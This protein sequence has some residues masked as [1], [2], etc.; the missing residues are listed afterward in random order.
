M[1]NLLLFFPLPIIGSSEENESFSRFLP[2]SC[3]GSHIPCD[4]YEPS[5][6][7]LYQ[8]FVNVSEIPVP[9]R[10]RNSPQSLDVF[11]SS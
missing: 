2:G 6:I 1:V 9:F 10:L 5:W 3:L 8:D 7:F 11:L 4:P